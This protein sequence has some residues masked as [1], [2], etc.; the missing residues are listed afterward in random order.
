MKRDPKPSLLVPSR[1]TH[2]S[3][4]SSEHSPH[5]TT[6]AFTSLPL[7]AGG[8]QTSCYRHEAGT[9]PSDGELQ[10]EAP[11][12]GRRRR[13]R[14]SRA[15]RKMK[16]NREGG[17]EA[18]PMGNPNNPNTSPCI[19]NTLVVG[20]LPVQPWTYYPFMIMMPL[21]VVPLVGPSQCTNINSGNVTHVNVVDSANNNSTNLSSRKGKRRWFSSVIIV[22]DLP[23]VHRK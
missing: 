13:S 5:T 2:S 12:T 10:S 3:L 16:V 14:R 23:L 21:P 15:A 6:N 9:T 1:D 20:G 17:M 11:N 8:A 7:H 18:H 4:L 22:A 19:P